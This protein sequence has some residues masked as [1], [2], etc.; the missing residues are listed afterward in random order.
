M[1]LYRHKKYVTK[2]KNMY[3][4]MSLRIVMDLAQDLEVIA[5]K[6]GLSVNSLIS[7]MAWD[8]VENW[9]NKYKNQSTK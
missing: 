8:F 3:K 9:K 2:E 5:K 1:I 7:E 4:R 6:R